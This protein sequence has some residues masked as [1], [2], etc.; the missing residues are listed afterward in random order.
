[1]L[2][3]HGLTVLTWGNASGID[4]QENVV[5]IKPSGV[6]Y[7]EMTAEHMV[8][9]DLISEKAFDSKYTPSSDT[10]THIALYKAFPNIGGV[11]HTHSRWATIFAQAGMSIPTLGTTH[12]D[13]F[14]GD[15]PCTRD[16]T[17]TEIHNLYEA[18]TGEVIVERFA[19]IDAN[20]V[21]A[22]LVKNHGPFVWG[23]D[24]TDAVHNAIVLEE[25]A[26][27]AWHN[28]I[29]ATDAQRIQQALLDK[30][31]KRKHGPDA[32]YGQL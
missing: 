15:I 18:S 2:P 1:L 7:E 6:S 14:Y 27:M 32:Y 25:I 30:H 4:R 5:V 12:A 11:V 21:P 26:F 13:Y 3:K 28:M 19:E 10:S 23:R 16:L 29:L 8:A 22:V 17:E 9:V 24:V 31:Y 20:S